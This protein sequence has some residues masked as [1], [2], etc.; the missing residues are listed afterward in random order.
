MM[1][2]KDYNE[3]RAA[4]EGAEM[5]REA[6]AIQIADR[7]ANN[8]DVPKELVRSYRE[9]QLAVESTTKDVHDCLNLEA[10]ISSFEEE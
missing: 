10:T 5:M 7:I 3:L 6:I 1:T 8:D 4:Q 9:A 2:M